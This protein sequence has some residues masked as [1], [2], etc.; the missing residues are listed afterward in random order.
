MCDEL[1]HTIVIATV[2]V[3]IIFVTLFTFCIHRYHKHA[4]KSPIA[5]AEMTFCRPAQG[6]PISYS[7]SG[8]RRPSLDSMENQV[9]VD[10]FKIP[11]RG[12]KR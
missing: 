1:C 4:H 7:S 3:F 2:L 6:F 8:T 10:S 9:S 5:S 12:L 11:V